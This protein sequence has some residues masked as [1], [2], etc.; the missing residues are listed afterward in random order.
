MPFIALEVLRELAIHFFHIL[1]SCTTKLNSIFMFGTLISYMR[2]M[3][4]KI[5][6]NLSKSNLL[7]A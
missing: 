4:R 2:F 6:L 1:E 3:V 7:D 5:A